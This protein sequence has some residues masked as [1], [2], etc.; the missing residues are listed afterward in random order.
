MKAQYSIQ[1]D[2]IIVHVASEILNGNI[3]N[4]SVGMF[5]PRMNQ[6]KIV[7]KYLKY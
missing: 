2:L 3:I 6:L 1:G 7:Q 4:G 5:V